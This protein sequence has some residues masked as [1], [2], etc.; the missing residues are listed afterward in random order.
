[1][2]SRARPPEGR[3]GFLEHRGARVA[4]ARWL[5]AR[6]CQVGNQTDER[7]RAPEVHRS[8]GV[9][10]HGFNPRANRG[11]KDH[12]SGEEQQRVGRAARHPE[13]KRL[14]D[15][16]SSRLAHGSC[17]PQPSATGSRAAHSRS[18]RSARGRSRRGHR[19]ARRRPRAR[20]RPGHRP[21]LRPARSA[22]IASPCARPRAVPTATSGGRFAPIRR[23]RRARAGGQVGREVLLAVLASAL[24]CLPDSQLVTLKKNTGGL[25]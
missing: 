10:R 11:H 21:A 13:G 16:Y 2:S 1:M 6:R 14:M 15:T 3:P 19:A 18:G 7:E 8:P 23:G 24:P 25:A 5:P 12:R 17:R 9:L 22:P 4:C 20:L